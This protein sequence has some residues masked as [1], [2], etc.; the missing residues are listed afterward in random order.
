MFN[1]QQI[2]YFDM[3]TE[4]HKAYFD[5]IKSLLNI[6]K[7]DK[8]SF[9]AEHM[10]F[11]SE[12]VKEM[13]EKIECNNSIKG[14]TFFE[15]IINSIS[16]KD[17]NYSGFSEFETYGTYIMTY[18]K[19]D[20][21]LRNWK[22]LREGIFYIQQPL[23]DKKVMWINKQYDAVS[24]EKHDTLPKISKLWNNDFF[25]SHVS[26][27]LV[28]KILYPFMMVRKVINSKIRSKKK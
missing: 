11:K 24:F 20:C 2:P 15:K 26:I 21:I 23:N 6:D 12:Y 10:I 9:I 17:L 27:N 4:Y 7:V 8:R 25:Y 1:K 14:N 22:S 13:I 5:T 3:K 19:E 18:H 28:T 16:D